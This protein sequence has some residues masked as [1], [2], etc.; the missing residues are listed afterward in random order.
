MKKISLIFL[1]FYSMVSFAFAEDLQKKPKAFL[2]ETEYQFEAV[3]EGSLVEK[4][5]IIVNKG[6][7]PLIIYEVITGC[8]CMTANY[9]KNIMP[10]EVGEIGIKV[11]TSYEGGNTV[12]HN[13]EI[14]SNDEN[15]LFIKI[16]G[17]V[18]KVYSVTPARIRLIGAVGQEISQVIKITPEAEYVFNVKKISAKPGNNIDV[19]IDNTV[20]EDS[21]LAVPD[22]KSEKIDWEKELGVK[23]C[24]VVIK[25]RAKKVGRYYEKLIIETDSEIMPLIELR[26]WGNIFS[27]PKED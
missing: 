19:M 13:I 21:L 16:F 20:R 26:V 18:K 2:P 25:N 9:S 17:K 8:G 14:K 11:D 3:P 15:K 7:A 1:F 27:K 23:S 4:K 22:K 6:K 24:Y 5:F 12:T 10:G